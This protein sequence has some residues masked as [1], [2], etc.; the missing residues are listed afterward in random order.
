MAENLKK[1]LLSKG[2]EIVFLVEDGLAR[3][4]YRNNEPLVSSDDIVLFVNGDNIPVQTTSEKTAVGHIGPW[5]K[6]SGGPVTLMTRVD[7]FFEGWEFE[8]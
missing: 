8:P 4:E 2:L 5:E 3:V 1:V 7:E 6:F